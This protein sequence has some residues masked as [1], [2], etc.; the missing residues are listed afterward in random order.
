MTL[1]TIMETIMKNEDN[2]DDNKKI[3]QN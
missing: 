3:I 2:N 1:I